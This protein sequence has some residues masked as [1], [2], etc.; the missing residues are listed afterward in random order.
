M[1]ESVAS[2]AL[3]GMF[4][5]SAWSAPAAAMAGPSAEVE[6]TD[7]TTPLVPKVLVKGDREF[8]G[9]G[10]QITTKVQLQI[11]EDRRSIKAKIFFRAVE[12]G[13]DRSTTEESFKVKVFEAPAGK[14]IKAI[15]GPLVSEV[16]FKSQRAGFQILGPGEDFAEFVRTVEEIAQKVMDAVNTIEGREGDTRKMRAAREYLEMVREGTAGLNFAGNH[17]HTISPSS[18][19][20]S[21]MAIVGDTGGDDISKDRNPKDDTR[22]QS[23]LFKKVRVKYE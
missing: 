11:S 9:N 5:L 18:G 20:V 8:G 13:G 19:P 7:I 23:I 6:L 21:V 1:F 15:E 22:I 12:T 4:A 3:A 16:N 14:Q 17:V 2:L 10:P